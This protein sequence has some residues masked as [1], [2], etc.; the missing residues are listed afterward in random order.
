VGKR[1]RLDIYEM[2]KISFPHLDLNLSLANLQLSHY[3]NHV[4]LPLTQ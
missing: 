3:T 1:D 2:R 4:T